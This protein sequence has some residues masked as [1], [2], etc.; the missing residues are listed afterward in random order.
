M[1][2]TYSTCW[3]ACKQYVHQD[4]EMANWQVGWSASF[5]A[6]KPAICQ[7]G[8]T[9]SKHVGSLTERTDGKQVGLYAGQ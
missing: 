6:N 3:Y 8:K 7:V 5:P 1:G 4:G 9:V 2:W